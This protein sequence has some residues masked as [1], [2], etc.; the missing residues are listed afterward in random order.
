MGGI[1]LLMYIRRISA[2][3][4]SPLD[5]YLQEARYLAKLVW[6]FSIG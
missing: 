1:L 5:E 4:S 2:D 3:V 6:D